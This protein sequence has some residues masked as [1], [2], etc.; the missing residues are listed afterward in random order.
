MRRLLSVLTLLAVV[1]AW[2]PA[3]ASGAPVPAPAPPV[4]GFP[5]PNPPAVGAK[6]WIL[7]DD[8]YGVVLGAKDPDLERPMAS[9]TKIMTALV[10]IEEGDLSSEIT[11]SNRAAAIGEAEIGLVP[12][13]TLPMKALVSALL[14]RS[15]NDAAMAVAEGV[16]G[17]VEGFVDLMNAKARELGLEHTSFANPHGL[18]APGH[19]SS[20]RDLLTMSLAGMEHSEF[21]GPVGSTKVAL[22]DSPEGRRRVASTTNRL[23]ERMDGVI[24][25]KTGF[26]SGALL[27]MV[28]AAERDGRRLYA[29]V[30]GSGGRGGHFDDA[31]ALLE[32]GFDEFGVVPVI[33]AG[34]PYATLRT[35]ATVER[36]TAAASVE[37]LMHLAASGVYGEPELTS[38]G[39]Q[40]VLTVEAPE[41]QVVELE[42]AESEPLPGVGEALAW[43]GRYWS[44]VTG[45]G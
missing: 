18:D 42:R 1:V 34:D 27:V 37:A 5:V 21:A 44:A 15:A 24:G 12:G 30:M 31:Q 16:G 2:G 6:T 7:Y 4:D 39:D 23:F 20:A 43:F 3:P 41:P 19:Y 33:A 25:V 36:L 8:T 38:D 45:N 13:E 35:S 9:T 17:T 29:V 32:Y 22:R 40:A 28:A 10:A 11:V 26:T 14:I